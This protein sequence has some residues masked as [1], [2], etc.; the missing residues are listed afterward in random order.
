MTIHHWHGVTVLAVISAVALVV[1]GA[2]I[3]A[4]VNDP[5]LV[6]VAIKRGDAAELAHAL[7]D[8]L[9]AAARA[10]LRWL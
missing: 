7:L 3:T 6:A 1:S 9:A 8:V 2:L 5:V 4:L 10:I